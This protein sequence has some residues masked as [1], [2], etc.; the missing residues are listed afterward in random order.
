VWTA[1]LDLQNNNIINPKLKT[2]QTKLSTVD[3]GYLQAP[4]HDKCPLDKASKNVTTV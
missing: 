1:T 2:R 3:V 4:G